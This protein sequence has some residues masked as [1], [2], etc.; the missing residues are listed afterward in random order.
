MGWLASNATT[1]IEGAHSL[2]NRNVDINFIL[3]I[4]FK[5]TEFH[6]IKC[7]HL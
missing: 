3:C 7:K 2:I 4:R 6:F 1:L 5:L